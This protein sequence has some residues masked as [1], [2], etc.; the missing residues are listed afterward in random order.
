[1]LPAFIWEDFL[2]VLADL[3]G[4]GMAFDPDWFKA[5]AEFR[6]PYCGEVTYEGVTLELRQA[7]EPWHVM[8]ETGAI[9]GTVRYTDSS[10]E[11]LQVTLTQRFQYPQG[12]FAT[13]CY[14]H[15]GKELFWLRR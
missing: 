3:R 14:A 11:R 1:M 8:G 6:F 9:G 7:L 12:G 2:D 5:Q 13:A 15:V 4:H 10:T